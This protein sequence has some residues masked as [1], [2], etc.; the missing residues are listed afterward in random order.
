MN[1]KDSVIVLAEFRRWQ[2]ALWCCH[3]MTGSDLA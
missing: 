2:L 3:C 1:M